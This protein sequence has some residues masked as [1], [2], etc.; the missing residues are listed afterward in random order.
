[1]LSKE[2]LTYTQANIFC[3]DNGGANLHHLDT[4][5][6]HDFKDDY[7][8]VKGQNNLG[9]R[10]INTLLREIMQVLRLKYQLSFTYLTHFI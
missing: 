5:T 1:M 6:V 9:M 8:L 10:N 2:E 3:N 7:E 4:N